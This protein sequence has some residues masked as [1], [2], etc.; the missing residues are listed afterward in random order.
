MTLQQTEKP[1][2][3]LKPIGILVGRKTSAV[4]QMIQTADPNKSKLPSAITAT[5][6]GIGGEII[7]QGAAEALQPE[8]VLSSGTNQ[9]S[10]HAIRAM[11][12]YQAEEDDEVSLETGEDVEFIK[13]IKGGWTMI[14]KEDNS[15]G[16]VP[17]NFLE[18]VKMEMPGEN[19]KDSLLNAQDDSI[20]DA[21]TNTSSDT[22]DTIDVSHE[23][24]DDHSERSETKED[25]GAERPAFHDDDQIQTKKIKFDEDKM[26]QD[27]IYLKL[28]VEKLQ[29]KIKVQDQEIGELKSNDEI[30]DKKIGELQSIFN[31]VR[32]GISS[33][34]TLAETQARTLSI[35]MKP[36]PNQVKMQ[37]QEI[38]E[39]K[40]RTVSINMKPPPNQV[41]TAHSQIIK[42]F[43]ETF[44]NKGIDLRTNGS[45]PTLVTVVHAS[46]AESDIDRDVKAVNLTK[47]ESENLILMRMIP[48]NEKDVD[49][50]VEQI[51]K[52]GFLLDL[53]ILCK[54]KP[55]E[56]Y[57]CKHNTEQYAKLLHYILD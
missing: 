56:P 18:S 3:P 37:D 21:E 45:N 6:A 50:K 14:R 33:S 38:G 48:T 10:Q 20:E 12:M 11:C 31:Q 1:P 19:A 24:D 53:S 15:V 52:E 26:S 47:E 30:K 23:G 42:Q 57:A 8:T 28:E 40:A 55:I 25:E 5:Q 16:L 54:R 13:V 49:K 27:I 44:S 4:D 43:K 9:R 32:K 51:D 34:Q 2:P 41:E 22:E 7:H 46:R 17:T 35:N 39:L 29:H 36:P